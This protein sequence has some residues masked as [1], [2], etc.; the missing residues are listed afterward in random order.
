MSLAKNVL[1]ALATA[2][3]ACVLATGAK[4]RDPSRW[5]P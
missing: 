5:R 2:V 4:A 3:G 1:L